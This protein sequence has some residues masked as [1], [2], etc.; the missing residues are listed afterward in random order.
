MGR[1]SLVPEPASLL[2]LEMAGHV[3]PEAGSLELGVTYSRRSVNCNAPKF[4]SGLMNRWVGQEG[5]NCLIVTL[6]DQMLIC[7][8]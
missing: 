2:V 7:V 1:C 6:C 5:H 8:I 4:R 3:V